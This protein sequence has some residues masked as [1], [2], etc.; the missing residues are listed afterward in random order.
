MENRKDDDLLDGITAG[1]DYKYGF[2]SDIDS[3]IIPP[4]LNE[5]VIRLISRKKGEPEWLLDFRLKAFRQWLKMDMPQWAHHDIP[6]IDYQAIS[7]YAAPRSKDSLLNT[8]P[9]PRDR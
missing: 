4:G 3:D 6:P 2:H 5:E 9:R 8:S 7:Y 1:D